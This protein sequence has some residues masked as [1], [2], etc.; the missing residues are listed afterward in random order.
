MNNSQ[1]KHKIFGRRRGRKKNK[2]IY[3]Q[4]NSSIEKYQYQESLGDSNKILD[5]G[6]GYGEV[7][8]YLSDIKP[9]H[10]IIAC[11]K[12]FDGHLNLLKQINANK[13][14]NI[15]I[16]NGSVYD[17]LQNLK[18]NKLFESIWIM[19][20]DPWPKKKHLKRRLINKNFLLFISNYLKKDGRI[21]I[22][23][24]VQNYILQILSSIFDCKHIFHW[25][26][27]Y[28]QYY[29]YKDYFIP[30]TKYFKK[31]IKS[32]RKPYFIILKRI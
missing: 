10:K 5:I 27:Q 30:E 7:S 32:G 29:D 23:S 8:I 14:N 4:F 28:N 21:Y 15:F 12:Y 6:S 13:I 11:D 2:E 3:T 25:E 22:A 1:K 26:N 17:F 24:D 16:Y 20:P 31:A 19:F 9:N 18:L